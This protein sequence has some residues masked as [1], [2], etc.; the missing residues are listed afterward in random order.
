MPGTIIGLGEFFSR[1]AFNST[2]PIVS[3]TISRSA[4]A[5]N[6]GRRVS[7]MWRGPALGLGEN[8]LDLLV[9]L[10]GRLLAVRAV[11]R[12]IIRG[13]NEHRVPALAI[14]GPAQTAHAVVHDHAAGDLRG[15]FQVVLGPRGDVAE[16]HFLRQG[17]RQE[18]LDAAFQ[19]AAG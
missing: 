5:S 16:N 12:Q 3:S 14:T 1:I 7:R 9:D 13:G 17:A 4:R 10:A 18:D 2:L 19:L 15:P 8:V 11:A 6:A